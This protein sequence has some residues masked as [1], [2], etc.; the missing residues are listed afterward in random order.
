MY[1][2]PSK[3]K[4]QKNDYQQGHIEVSISLRG[5]LHQLVVGYIQSM[6]ELNL[7]TQNTN[8]FNDWEE[9]LNLVPSDRSLVP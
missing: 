3:K 9:N 6:E 8:P 2:K 1:N 5:N 7:G 4:R